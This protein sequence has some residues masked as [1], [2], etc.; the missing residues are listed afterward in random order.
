MVNC[1][2]NQWFE[3]GNWFE[4]SHSCPYKPHHQEISKNRKLTC[5]WNLPKME[6][7]DPQN[8]IIIQASNEFLPNMKV[9]DLVLPFPK[10]PR[11]LISHVWLASY[12]QIILKNFWTSKW[13][14]FQTIWPNWV[15]FFAT[16][17]IWHALSKSFI[18]F[19]QKSSNQNGLFQV[20]W[21][22]KER[23]EKLT[24]KLIIVHIFYQLQMTEN[25]IWRLFRPIFAL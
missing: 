19:H 14:N 11:T 1:A 24:F 9:E 5:N 16:S 15:R 21:I 4:R 20:H 3:G 17:H 13:D 22:K 23:G 2:F 10:S 7:L 12:D 18:T 8:Y 6:S 25:H